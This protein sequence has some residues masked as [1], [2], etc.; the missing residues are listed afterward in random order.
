MKYVQRI[1]KFGDH[2][3][4]QDAIY[5]IVTGLYH[6]ESK[7]CLFSYCLLLSAK[8]RTVHSR[9]QVT[10]FTKPIISFKSPFYRST[11]STPHRQ[12]I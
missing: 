2:L 7:F 3:Q 4:L 10:H 1:R 5:S 6:R 12:Q 11:F 8:R 9:I